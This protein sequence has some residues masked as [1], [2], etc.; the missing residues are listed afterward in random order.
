M[1][2]I[3]PTVPSVQY[4]SDCLLEDIPLVPSWTEVNREV[5]FFPDTR[6]VTTEIWYEIEFDGLFLNDYVFFVNVY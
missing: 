5:T 4:I 2:F 6:E 1:N 3:I